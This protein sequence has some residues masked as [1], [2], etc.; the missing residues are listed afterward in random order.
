MGDDNGVLARAI[1]RADD[2]SY[3]RRLEALGAAANDKETA[4]IVKPVESPL[5]YVKH[6]QSLLVEDPSEQ[7]RILD[8]AASVIKWS[9][10]LTREER[11]ATNGASNG[12]GTHQRAAEESNSE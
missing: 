5:W 2:L 8:L 7:Q 3:D 4:L 11:A 9:A 12:H 6:E 1:K 10:E